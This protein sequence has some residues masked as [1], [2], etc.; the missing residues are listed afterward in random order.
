M[1]DPAF[2]P[3]PEEFAEKY[4]SA[5]Y[6]RGEAL[7]NLLRASATLYPQRTAVVCGERRW[8]YA[9]LDKKADSFAAGLHDLGLRAGDR[10]VVQLPNRAEFLVACFALFRLGVLPVFALP[11][12]RRNEI[13]YFCKFAEARACIIADRDGGFDYR[14]MLREVRAESLSLEHVIVVGEPEELCAFDTLLHEPKNFV[15]P[16]ASG[17]GLPAALRR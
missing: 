1:S 9:E 10:V 12:H 16:D 13:A 6:W 4:R 7:G 14:Q 5:G 15:A 17:L 2:T 3:W 11:A 8:S